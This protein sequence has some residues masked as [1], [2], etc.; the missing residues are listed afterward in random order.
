MTGYK[1]KSRRKADVTKGYLALYSPFFSSLFFGDFR[2]SNQKEIAIEDVDMNEFI[3][4]LQVVYP[5][6]KCVTA[7]SVEFLLKLGDRFQI[8]YV[9]DNCVKFLMKTEEISMIRKLLWA[10]Q[11]H[12]ASLQDACIRSYADVEEIEDLK[13]TAEYG[14]LSD[15]SKLALVEKMLNLK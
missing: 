13:S 11:Y 9:M 4:L 3:G 2:H 12:L 14:K 5:S 6:H 8:Q 1:T 15:T 7:E 10:D